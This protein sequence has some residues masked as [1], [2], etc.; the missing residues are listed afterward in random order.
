MRQRVSQAPSRFYVTTCPEAEAETRR[1]CLAPVRVNVLRCKYFCEPLE[2]WVFIVPLARIVALASSRV[3]L[4]HALYSILGNVQHRC[5]ASIV[6]DPHG[7]NPN[8]N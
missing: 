5:S 8:C 6:I 1:L 2:A 4:R 7:Q 3:L